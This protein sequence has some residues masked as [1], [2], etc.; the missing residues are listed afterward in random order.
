MAASTRC[1][2]SMSDD[3][4]MDDYYDEDED[5]DSAEYLDEDGFDAPQVEQSEAAYEVLD[6]AQCLE[7]AQAQVRELS[8]LLCCESET[9]EWLLRDFRWD[10]EKLTEGAAP[11]PPV[12]SHDLH[13]LWG[14]STLL[15]P[16]DRNR[17]CPAY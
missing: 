9:A 3:E 15:L 2:A 6:A 14:G 17:A 10:R 11:S 4:S 1:S 5:E 8:E 13:Q 7:L 16:V 12:R